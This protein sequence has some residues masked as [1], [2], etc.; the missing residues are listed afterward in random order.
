VDTV[1]AILIP[2]AV[3]VVT[4]LLADSAK[5]F[6]KSEGGCSVVGY[7]WGMKGFALFLGTIPVALFVVLIF[8]APQDRLP[9]LHMILLFGLLAAYLL[10]ESFCV[11][12]VFSP[13]HI[14]AFSP[15]R[16]N[17]KFRWEE[18]TGVAFSPM[19]RW[20]RVSTRAQGH[21]R[22]HEFKSGVPDFLSELRRR[23]IA[24]A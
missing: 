20:H 6:A 15:W 2:L 9:V 7:G 11:R 21:I 16:K 3:I 14:Q 23:G 19:A 24:G 4:G 13:E 22:L 17:R 5:P 8:V 18:I 10:L 1:V 12:V